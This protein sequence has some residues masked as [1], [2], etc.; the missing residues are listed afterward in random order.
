MHV[1]SCFH[2]IVDADHKKQG[3]ASSQ[4]GR[5]ALALAIIAMLGAAFRS[6]SNRASALHVMI[7]LTR[8]S[9]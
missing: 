8:S 4:V 9:E 5:A 2:V 1:A 3:A 7:Q 6:M